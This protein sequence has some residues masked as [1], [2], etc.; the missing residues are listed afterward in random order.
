MRSE[1]KRINSN[2]SAVNVKNINKR[3]NKNIVSGYFYILKDKTEFFNE[4][5]LTTNLFDKNNFQLSFFIFDFENKEIK[6]RKNQIFNFNKFNRL[7]HLNQLQQFE[8]ER[9]LENGE[10]E[11]QIDKE[12][13]EDK[14]DKDEKEANKDKEQEIESLNEYESLIKFQVFL[15]RTIK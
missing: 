9:E 15:I 6:Y 3:R 11:K 4:A 1:V 5:S 8:N 14:E 2:G 12:D 7:K 10:I 13:K